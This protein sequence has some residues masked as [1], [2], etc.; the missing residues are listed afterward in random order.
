MRVIGTALLVGVA[1]VLVALAVANRQPVTVSLDP[2]GAAPGASVTLPLYAVVFAALIA[3]VVL[4]GTAVA[5][6][7]RRSARPPAPRG[8][9]RRRTAPDPTAPLPLEAPASPPRRRPGL[10]RR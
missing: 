5:L 1:A 10:L 4:G 3:G 9:R 2:L 6:S 8:R 7:R